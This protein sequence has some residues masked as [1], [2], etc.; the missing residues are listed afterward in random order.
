MDTYDIV[1]IGRQATFQAS[2]PTTAKRVKCRGTRQ[3]GAKPPQPTYRHSA[4]D[5]LSGLLKL[6]AAAGRKLR[7]SIAAWCRHKPTG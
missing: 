5:S 2:V 7:R 3:A 1:V 4:R 6:A